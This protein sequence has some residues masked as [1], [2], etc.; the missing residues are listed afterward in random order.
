ME[1]GR[2]QQTFI[3]DYDCLSFLYYLL[4]VL[5]HVSWHSDL[6]SRCVSDGLTAVEQPRVVSLLLC[7]SA[8]VFTAKWRYNAIRKPLSCHSSQWRHG[9]SL[10]SLTSLW[11]AEEFLVFPCRWTGNVPFLTLNDG[12]EAFEEW[13]RSISSFNSSWCA[14]TII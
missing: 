9:R 1:G 5:F 3:S 12:E 8:R 10:L 13:K 14:T 4:N 11:R 2:C 7:S 6:F